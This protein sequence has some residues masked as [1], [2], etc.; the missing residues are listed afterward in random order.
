MMTWFLVYLTCNCAF[1]AGLLA[2]DWV[3]DKEKT[4][5]VLNNFYE[6]M[7]MNTFFTT[8]YLVVTMALVSIPTFLIRQIKG[9]K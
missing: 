7:P 6:E 8:V 3:R 4:N 5:K 1:S 9:G 2:Y